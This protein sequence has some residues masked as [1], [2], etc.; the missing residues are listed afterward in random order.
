MRA[1]A[2][3]LLLAFTASSVAVPADVTSFAATPETSVTEPDFPISAGTSA[4]TAFGFGLAVG[5][6]FT[7]GRLLAAWAD[8]SESLDGNPDRPALD[9]GF[10]TAVGGVTGANVNV[11]ALSGTQL[12]PSLAADPSNPDIVVAAAVDRSTDPV[13]STLRAFSRDGGLT[14]TVV[15]GLPGNFG[16][17]PP[18]VAFDGSGNCFLALLHDPDFGSAH[19]ELFVSTDG[20][21]T[22]TQVPLPDPPGLETSPSI[23]AGFRSVWV[24]FQTFDGEVTRIGTLAAP[25]TGPGQVGEFTVQTLP[26]SK[27]GKAPDVALGIGG[28]AVVAYAQGEFSPAPTIDVNVDADGL[29]SGGF[30]PRVPVANA[31]GRPNLL[32][33]AVSADRNT[34]RMYV[35]YSDRQ[36]ADGPDEVRL[37]FSDDGTSWSAAITVNDP[38]DSPNRLLPNVSLDE[39]GAIGTA[40]YDFRSGGAELRGRILP[41]VDLPAEPR[42]PLTLA[43]APASQSRIDLAWTDASD[44]EEGFVVERRR[45][46]PDVDANPEIV[47][48]LPANTTAWPDDGLRA[49]TA[50]LYRV[51]A[52]NRAGASLWSNG[53]AATTLAVP[54]AAPTGL[55][56][57]AVTFQRIDLAWS[58]VEGAD[59]YEVQQSLDGVGFETIARPTGTSL[60]VFGLQPSTRYFF[61]VAAVNSGGT[62]PFSNVVSATTLPL[63]DPGTPTGL[64]ATA[65]SSTRILLEWRDNSVGETHFEVQRSAAGGAFEPAGLAPADAQSFTDTRLRRSTT[66]SYRVRSCTADLCSPFSSIVSATTPKR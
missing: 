50:F 31:P 38:V 22:F 12:S 48:K 6:D 3:T 10:A 28:A 54:P 32:R 18:S 1:I 14:W 4:A 55:T 58:A 47:A 26:E 57:T 52:F 17:F 8:N 44:N 11:T 9:I 45:A 20:G 43:A 53:A 64:R 66:F 36:E 24:A 21:V 33:P 63:A 51:R 60:L 19:V 37:S 16:A 15:R 62:S 49:D 27:G 30:G 25:V 42:A 41:G 35:V 29:G 40:W 39:S 46:T 61:R 56:A 2:L 34:G 59:S 13:P 23:A 5:L 65:L 7:G